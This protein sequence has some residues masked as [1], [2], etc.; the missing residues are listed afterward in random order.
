MDLA[1]EDNFVNFISR[2]FV[3]RNYQFKIYDA[4]V[5][6]MLSDNIVLNV[7]KVNTDLPLDT[8]SE[9]EF[10]LPS[11]MTSI[12]LQRQFSVPKDWA[13]AKHFG[14]AST[15]F[16]YLFSPDQMALAEGNPYL[17]SLHLAATKGTNTPGKFPKPTQAAVYEMNVDVG[18]FMDSVVAK[19][20][21]IFIGDYYVSFAVQI[22]GIVRKFAVD[23]RMKVTLR[24]PYLDEIQTTLEDKIVM[25]G[26]LRWV[27]I[28][29]SAALLPRLRYRSSQVDFVFPELNE[30]E[31]ER[32]ELEG[33]PG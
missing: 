17:L 2:F 15:N 32:G 1:L 21:P 3:D 8:Q 6:K 33:P 20:L 24:L 9:I 5:G 29:A 13:T 19:V 28:A 31:A 4:Y 27:D 11:N 7:T 26:L 25:S 14:D 10:P 18:P 22:F 30:S 16:E 23:T 12:P